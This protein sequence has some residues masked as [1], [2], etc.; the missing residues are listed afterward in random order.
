MITCKE[1][2]DFLGDYASGELPPE[3]RLVFESHLAICP[4][5][6]AYLKT[7]QATIRLGRACAA[8]DAAATAEIP[9]ELVR[10]ILASRAAPPS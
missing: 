3:Q 10:A 7:Y 4:P 1:L 8:D 9:E 6:V 2:I 5:C